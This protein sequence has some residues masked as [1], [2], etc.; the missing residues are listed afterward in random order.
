MADNKTHNRWL[1]IPWGIAAV[2]LLSY[3]MLWRYG[4]AEM[5]SAVS[6]WVE[7]QRAAGVEVSHGALKADGFPFFLR[8]HIEDP[9]IAAP[10]TGAWRT[11]RLTIDALPYDLN[12]L[13]FSTRTEQFVSLAGHGDWR[14]SAEDFRI[15]IA[16]DK[17]RDWVFAA[18]IGGATARRDEDGATA[19]VGS[20]IL[21]L[22]PEETDKTI[23]TLSVLATEAQVT[24]GGKNI[25]LDKLQTVV[26][27][28]EAYALADPDL[29]RKAGGA[30]QIKGVFAQLEE[31]RF[32]AAGTLRLDGEG[33]PQGDLRTEIIAP[34]PFV[35][36]LGDAGVIAPEDVESAA[37]SLT[38]ASIAAGGKLT[39][40]I[41]FKDGAAHVAGVRLTGVASGRANP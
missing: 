13:I 39:A 1:Y 31:A 26:A 30:L 29:W 33:R 2:V 25:A 36:L 8:L 6:D 4:A 27:A 15:S 22:S 40:P 37:A 24:A 7:D 21:D 5:K 9:Y 23:L 17:R 3:L 11:E 16:N 20:L 10:E 41:E 14:M 32:A 35:H 34:A 12:R 19:S 38:L 18:T 28:S